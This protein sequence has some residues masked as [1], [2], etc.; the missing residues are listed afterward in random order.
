MRLAGWGRLWRVRGEL[1][2][3]ALIIMLDQATKAWAEAHLSAIAEGMPLIPGIL[4]LVHTRNIGAAFSM[5]PGARPLL[6]AVTIV[7]LL[8]LIVAYIREARRGRVLRLAILFT[9]A[10]GAGNLVDRIRMGYVVDFIEPLFVRFA[11]FNVADIS[12]TAGATLFAI[13]LLF[14]EGKR[15][16]TDARAD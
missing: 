5:L 10:G 12:V 8:A 14:L 16:K 15:G 13:W 3:A 1:A 9:F 4:R 11:V 2:A 6:V 7:F